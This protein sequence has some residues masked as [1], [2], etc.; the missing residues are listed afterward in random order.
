MNR[1]KLYENAGDWTFCCF[2]LGGNLSIGPD[3]VYPWGACL[4]PWLPKNQLS[5]KGQDNLEPFGLHLIYYRENRDGF[6][7]EEGMKRVAKISN[8]NDNNINTK[9]LEDLNNKVT[10]KV[11]TSTGKLSIIRR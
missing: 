2:W 10:L 7:L 11:D 1:R 8:L 5:K 6:V 3:P 9:V 4:F